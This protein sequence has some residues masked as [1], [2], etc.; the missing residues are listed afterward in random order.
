MCQNESNTRKPAYLS[1]PEFHYANNSLYARYGD[2]PSDQPATKKATT[3]TADHQLIS[4]VESTATATANPEKAIN[5]ASKPT[6]PPQVVANA[7][8]TTSENQASIITVRVRAST[9]DDFIELDVDKRTTSFD[10]FK[11]MCCRELERPAASVSKI[12]KLPNLLVR[13]DRD[14]QRLVHEQHVELVFSVTNE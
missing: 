12:R 13:N 4:R 10:A 7:V 6:S 5:K 1:H 9:D 2:T 14:I 3:H 11:A 8:T